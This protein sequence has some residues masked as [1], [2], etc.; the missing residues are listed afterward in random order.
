MPAFVSTTQRLA[1]K[2]DAAAREGRVE[3]ML[4]H[5]AVFTLEVICKV[6]KDCA[7]ASRS[8]SCMI[9]GRSRRQARNVPGL[10]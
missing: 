5:T 7:R 9:A 6:R 1:C 10:A 2:L 4:E 8:P 3:R